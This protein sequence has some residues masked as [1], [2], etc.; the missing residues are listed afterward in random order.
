[1][2]TLKVKLCLI[3]ALALTVIVAL[4]IFIGN[5]AWANRYLTLSGT[6]IFTTSGKAEVWAHREFIGE[7]ENSDEEFD[8]TDTDYVYYTMFSF[9]KSDDAVSYKRNLAYNW[10]YNA[11]DTDDYIRE[12]YEG[13]NGN[14]WIYEQ[15][16]EIAYNGDDECTVGENGNWFIGETDT[17]ISA[18]V[19]PDM[20]EGYLRME[21]GFE[22]A[23]FKKFV[24]TFE[25]QQFN[26]T[27]DEK[28][29]NY[30]IFVPTVDDAG[31]VKVYAVVTSDK[32]V[33]DGEVEDIDLTG[34]KMLDIDHIVIQ[35]GE[36]QPDANGL[37]TKGDYD[38][39]VFNA[40]NQDVYE[41]GTFTNVG[42]MYAKYV[43]SSTK[44]VT[45]LSFKAEFEEDEEGN[46]SEGQERARMAIYELNGQSFRLTSTSTRSIRQENDHIVGGQV[47]DTQPPV[48]CLDS[49]ISFVEKNTE[50][51]FSYTAVDVLTQSPTTETYFFMLTNADAQKS[52]D[53]FNPDNFDAERLFKKV[54]SDE[55]LYIYPHASHYIP[56]DGKDY[57]ANGYG[58]AFHAGTGE[59]EDTEFLPAA[60]VKIYLKLT[61]TVS[62]GGQSTYVFLD[63]FVEKEYLL[64]VNGHD[65]I[66]VA[67]DGEGATFNYGE[68]NNSF[69]EDNAIWKAYNEKVQEAAK[70]LRAGSDEDFYLPSV[71]TLFSDN[72]TAYEDMTFAIY[73]MVNGTTSSNASRKSSQLYIDLTTDGE[74]LFT[75][76]AT[77]ASGNSMWYWDEEEREV[78]KFAANQI[79]TMYDDENDEGLKNRLPWFRFTAGISD[80]SIEDPGEQ[81]TAYV[82]ISYTASGFTVKGISTKAEYTLYRFEHEIYAADND[83]KVLTY[84]E[85][86]EIK[87]T[88]FVEHG[89]YFTQ[90]E[91]QSKLNENSEEYDEFYAYA[92]NASNRSFIPQ[93]ENAFYLIQCE[94]SSTRFPTREHVKEYMGIAASATPKAISGENTWV[95]DNM[96][97]II[98]LSIAGA[99]FIGIIV[100]LFIKP[101]ESGDIDA[102]F[103]Q[104]VAKKN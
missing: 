42:K 90:I 60:A 18:T 87:N 8:I 46:L 1:M 25:T 68:G 57:N 9:E 16:T 35:L 86:M 3:I 99:A 75:V 28:T 69:S 37:V 15:D 56:K 40:G 64:N 81:S 14:W 96:V 33:A 21:I 26:M 38:V 31:N 104:E 51:S 70:D 66:A 44:P 82:G 89:E 24:I 30:I 55:D 53:E 72:A 74:Y 65:Y 19:L 6:S 95:K 58:T 71:E 63:W 102:Q 92:W 41:Q 5:E 7:G 2:K 47:N 84:Q 20:N 76:Y 78:V 91:E 10:Y 13:K 50:L 36:A 39:K 4:G 94:V 73:Y 45:P 32:E 93:D 79:W 59:N 103:E 23:N 100:L 22:A 29:I 27:K 97:S 88:L 61:D 52:D 54:T 77:D 48:L 12:P 43:S 83:G 49:G 80:I 62:D 11:S 98:L 17:G 101:K 67:A 85:F 34:L